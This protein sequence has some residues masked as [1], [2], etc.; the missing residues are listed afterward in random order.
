VHRV[1][2]PDADQGMSRSLVRGIDALQGSAGPQDGLMILPA[3]MPLVQTSTLL[4]VAREIEHHPV[5]Y[6]QYRGRRGH[7]V[8]F[9]AELYSELVLLN[10]DEGARRLVARYP[11]YGVE[12]GDPGVL[13]DIDTDADLRAARALQA[14]P[15]MHP[16]PPGA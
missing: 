14:A 11:A 12:V 15:V 1:P 9:A 5:A 3:D 13:V 8:G 4:A 10:G 7:P 16:A 2:V 6:A